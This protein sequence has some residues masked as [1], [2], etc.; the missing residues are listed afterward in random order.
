[1]KPG[2]ASFKTPAEE[3]GLV[4]RYPD[5]GCLVNLV[6]DYD[7][8]ELG[9]YLPTEHFDLVRMS[10]YGKDVFRSVVIVGPS[11]ARPSS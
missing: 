11:E 5:E 2:D 10:R 6:G 3:H 9:H 1:M 4:A 7:Y 8:L